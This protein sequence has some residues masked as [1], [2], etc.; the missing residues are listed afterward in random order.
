MKKVKY[1]LKVRL[2][3]EYPGATKAAIR[4]Y[5]KSAIT[6]WGGGGDSNSVFFKSEKNV[7]VPGI[8]EVEDA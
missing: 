6:Y 5:V 7:T 8:R 3:L 2:E 4:N 1:V